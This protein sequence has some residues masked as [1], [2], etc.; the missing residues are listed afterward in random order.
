M[1]QLMLSAIA[2]TAFGVM[3]TAAQAD[4][5]N[6]QP[7]QKG[8]QCWKNQITSGSRDAR[9]GYWQACPQTASAAVT[10]R[11]SRRHRSSR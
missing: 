2:L 10:P 1:R 6:G 11:Q 5:L 9:W 8:N 3:L 7:V 4:N